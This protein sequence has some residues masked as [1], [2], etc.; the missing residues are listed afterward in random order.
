MK[1]I[2]CGKEL[3]EQQD[4]CKYC[5]SNLK[6][7]KTNGIIKTSGMQEFNE[8]KDDYKTTFIVGAA[9]FAISAVLCGL[10]L[11]FNFSYVLENGISSTG[12]LFFILMFPY[13]MVMFLPFIICSITSVICF[14][15]S[16]KS[17]NHSYAL[18]SKLLLIISS[19]ILAVTIFFSLYASIIV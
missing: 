16:V 15:F 12:F 8:G 19:A 7:S 14:I 18:A 4:Y 6:A 13:T 1:C 10:L 5:K 17:Y 9:T 2:Y 3:K 11:W